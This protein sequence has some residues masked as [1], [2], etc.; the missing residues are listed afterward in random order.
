MPSSFHRVYRNDQYT[1]FL[2]LYSASLQD[3]P[4]QCVNLHAIHII[5]LLQRLL[6]LPLVRLDI[7]DEDQRIVLLNLLHRTLRIQRIDDHFVMI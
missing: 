1:C 4:D 5:Q 2:F 6:D 7:A 3:L